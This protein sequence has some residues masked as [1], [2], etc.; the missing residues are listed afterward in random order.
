MKFTSIMLCV[1]LFLSGCAINKGFQNN[2]AGL[3]NLSKGKF[4]E[5]EREFKSAVEISPNNSMYHNNLGAAYLSQGR[6]DEGY[7]EFLKAIE[8]DENNYSA[9]SGLGDVY[10]YQNKLEKS[11]EEYKKT[12]DFLVNNGVINLALRLVSVSYDLNS[13][14]KTISLFEDVIKNTK[15]DSIEGINRY[16]VSNQAIIHGYLLQGKYSDALQRASDCL[17]ILKQTKK[18]AGGYVI[19]IITPFFIFVKSVPN[20]YINLDNLYHSFYYF[21]SLAYF[22]QGLYKEALEEAKKAIDKVS[23]SPANETIGR[24]MLE[25]GNT[26]EALYYLRKMHEKYPY[27]VTMQLS[28]AI[29][30]KRTGDNFKADEVFQEAIKTSKNKFDINLK[31]SYE[32]LF[33]IAYF[34]QVSQKYDDAISYYKKTIEANPNYGVAY[35]KLGEIYYQRNEKELAFNNLKQALEIMPDSSLVKYREE[36]SNFAKK[37]STREV[38]QQ[39]I[40]PLQ[41]PK[42]TN[43]TDRLQEL[44][45]LK[46]KGF[47]T[48]EEYQKKRS[49]ILHEL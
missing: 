12:L 32:Y 49:E 34:Y 47:I 44:K 28:Y 36:I 26:N 1:F 27:Q 14:D 20:Q 48:E 10:V 21:K 2:Q 37:P 16:F 40:T 3:V 43:V 13:I 7:K 45:S 41:S 35:K 4:S 30:L 24:I 18:E 19:P 9:H 17:E 38:P 8:L 31:A 46:D 23:E 5:A 39:I 42:E 29:A 25:E 22:Q 11:Y 6:F 33:N 15:T